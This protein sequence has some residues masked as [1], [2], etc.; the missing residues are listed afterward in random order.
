MVQ[1]EIDYAD[2]IELGFKVK[3]LE[4]KVFFNQRGYNYFSVT[5]KLTK[6][7]YLDWDLEDRLVHIYR[8]K[9]GF[10][11]NKKPIYNLRHLKEIINFFIE[12]DPND[13]FNQSVTG[14]F[15]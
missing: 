12:K 14:I 13:E 8:H 9:K 7:I 5:K 15:F 10:H 4:D 2:V 1:E 6:W 3:Y 11:E